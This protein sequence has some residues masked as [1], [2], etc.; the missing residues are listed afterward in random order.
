MKPHNLD[1]MIAVATVNE[2][3]VC[4][5]S[6][7]ALIGNDE[8]QFLRGVDEII[9]VARAMAPDEVSMLWEAFEKMQRRLLSLLQEKNRINR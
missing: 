8:T 3:A 1:V 4:I 7:S 2:K 6:G 9:E 5:V